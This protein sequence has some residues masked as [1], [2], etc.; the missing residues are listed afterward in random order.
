MTENLNDFSAPRK[1]GHGFPLI[2]SLARWRAAILKIIYSA[3]LSLT[4]V[5]CSHGS[6]DVCELAGGTYFFT[7]NE[8]DLLVFLPKNKEVVFESPTTGSMDG[9]Y[10]MIDKNHIRIHMG[11]NDFTLTVESDDRL[12]GWTGRGDLKIKSPSTCSVLQTSE[13]IYHVILQVFFAVVIAG[14]AFFWILFSRIKSRH[15][16]PAGEVERG[17]TH[18]QR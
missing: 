10:F 14:L 17:D 4:L 8:Q 5:A 2:F 6:G 1:K 9:S 11:G 16:N 18:H 13:K 7:Q 3:A 12:T 15:R